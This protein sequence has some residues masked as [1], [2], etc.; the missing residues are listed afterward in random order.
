MYPHLLQL[1]DGRV[2]LTF[3]KRCNPDADPIERPACRQDGHGTGLRALLSKDGESWDWGKDYMVL[4]EQ[5]DRY[6]TVPAS[7]CAV[8]APHEPQIAEKEKDMIIVSHD[9]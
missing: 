4:S 2:L 6:P 1:R 3:T 9:S 7:G 5:D 8:A